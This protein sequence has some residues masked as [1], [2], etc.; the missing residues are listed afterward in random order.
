LKKLYRVSIAGYAH[1]LLKADNE[2][3]SPHVD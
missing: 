2:K 3:G 1:T